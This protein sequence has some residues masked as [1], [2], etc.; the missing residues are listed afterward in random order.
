MEMRK[1]KSHL[2]SF[3]GH[4][5]WP[6]GEIS[7]K[8]RLRDHQIYFTNHQLVDFIIIQ[9]PS[10]YKI[11]FGRRSMKKFEAITPTVH[12]LIRFKISR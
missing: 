11:I 4:S 12:G 3:A 9:S 7:L 6:L 5:V 2:T 8:F 10:L 1:T